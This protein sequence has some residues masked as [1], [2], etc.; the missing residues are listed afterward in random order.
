MDRHSFL[1]F[2]LATSSA[3]LG[4]CFE[5]QVAGSSGA[6]AGSGGSTTADSTTTGN[7]CVMGAIG[8][9][10]TDG[11]GCDGVL[12]C[13][14]GTCISSVCGNEIQ[15][16]GEECD[17]GNEIQADD[18][19]STCVLNRCGDG[20]L[21]P[22]AEQ[23]D[24]GVNGGEDRNCTEECSWATCGDGR[25]C[26]APDCTSGPTGGAEECDDGNAIE[27]DACRN[28]CSSA[29]CGDGIVWSGEEECDDG[30]ANANTAACTLV[31]EA[32]RCGDGFIHDGV[33]ACERGSAVNC[34]SLGW[35]S[36]RIAS[37]WPPGD[38]NACQ[39]YGCCNY[40]GGS[41]VVDE[42]CC[43]AGYSCSSETCVSA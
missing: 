23:C 26:V 24:D 17:D 12:S 8:C 4:G 27:T 13:V 29:V 19:L 34:T 28:D 22:N 6:T 25:T 35:H 1:R 5:D 40:G 37:C 2:V 9:P 33:E 38:P 41:C 15:D 14:G 36:D 43:D 32:A 39:A 16:E 31:C 10:C 21:N 30:E 20:F 3:A 42:D 11:G 18:C 7:D